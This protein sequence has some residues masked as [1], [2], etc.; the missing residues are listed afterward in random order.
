MKP[1]LA[2]DADDVSRLGKFEEGLEGG[3]LTLTLRSPTSIPRNYRKSLF[4]NNRELLEKS[5]AITESTEWSG[6]FF[7]VFYHV[8]HTVGI[9]FAGV[10][11]ANAT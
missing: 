9:V 11:M 3:R 5:H 10:Y 6:R 2:L 4:Y 8:D 1:F 7:D